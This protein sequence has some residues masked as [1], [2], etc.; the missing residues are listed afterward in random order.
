MATYT[1]NGYNELTA[2]SGTPGRGTKVNVSGTIPTGNRGT[3]YLL[4]G[5]QRLLDE[6]RDLRRTFLL[7]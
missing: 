1:N 6:P 2:V 4:R 5:M 3:P 7:V